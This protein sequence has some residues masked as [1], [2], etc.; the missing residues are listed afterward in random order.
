MTPL[1]RQQRVSL[2][3]VHDRHVPE[4]NYLWFRRQVLN[5]GEY[6]LIN[7][8]WGYLGIERDGYTHS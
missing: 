4:K 6:I 2:K 7:V 8:G 5:Y 3:Q 1:T